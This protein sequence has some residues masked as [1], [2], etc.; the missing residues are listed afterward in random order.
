MKRET[1]SFHTCSNTHSLWPTSLW[2]GWGDRGT[3][4]QWCMLS[5][6]V[7]CQTWWSGPGKTRVITWR[8][9]WWPWGWN[10][11]SRGWD[12]SGESGV[13]LGRCLDWLGWGWK[14]LGWTWDTHGRDW[15]TKVRSHQA[16]TGEL[17]AQIGE[18]QVQTGPAKAKKN[19][20]EVKSHLAQTG[21]LQ[22]QTW[23]QTSQGCETLG[24]GQ[25]TSGIWDT[26][27]RLG[28]T[29]WWC[30]SSLHGVTLSGR[31][32]RARCWCT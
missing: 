6:S 11:L 28:H 16:K 21:D 26:G 18:L 17:Q 25:G 27:W 31:L 22:I 32:C 20:A 30:W 10:R 4:N 15:N 12:S 13:K 2:W 8:W 1:D 14:T 7:C 19:W 9:W 23:A 5:S 24:V 29:R 3:V